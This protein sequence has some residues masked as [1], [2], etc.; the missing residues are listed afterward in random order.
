MVL[1][2]ELRSKYFLPLTTG[3][4]NVAFYGRELLRRVEPLDGLC[5]IMQ[6]ISI[7]VILQKES[8]LL[9][10]NTTSIPC[11]LHTLQHAE[12]FRL[13]NLKKCMSFYKRYI[14]LISFILQF[15]YRQ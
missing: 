9:V 4:R 3:V 12:K 10:V 2:T 11:I 8:S 14:V 1:S 5:S 7:P 13:H 15:L 6:T